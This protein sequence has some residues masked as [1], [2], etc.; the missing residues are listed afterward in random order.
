MTRR[1]SFG[2][3]TLAGCTDFDRGPS[4]E[5]PAMGQPVA[6]QHV[7]AALRIGERRVLLIRHFMN[8]MAYRHARSLFP[9]TILDSEVNFFL[10]SEFRVR[11]ASHPPE[12]MPHRKG[13]RDIE[14]I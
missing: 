4:Y 2:Y 11:R 1:G 14:S 10:R 5:Q 3:R 12:A 7:W 13:D 8:D 9:A 6:G